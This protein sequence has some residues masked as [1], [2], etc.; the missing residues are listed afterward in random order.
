M[1]WEPYYHTTPPPSSEVLCQIERK[2]EREPEKEGERK[3]K[4]AYNLGSV[5]AWQGQQEK[6]RS[7]AFVYIIKLLHVPE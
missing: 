3:F 2:S 6:V 7:G 5:V 4:W 1:G